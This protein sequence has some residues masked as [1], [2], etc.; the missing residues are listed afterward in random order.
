MIPITGNIKT[1][2]RNPKVKII[3]KTEVMVFLM[4]LFSLNGY[5]SLVGLLFILNI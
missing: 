4:I 1:K 5:F 3:P 2:A